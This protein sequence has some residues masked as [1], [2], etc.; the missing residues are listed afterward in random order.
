MSDATHA[1]FDRREGES[2]LQE[3]DDF[4]KTINRDDPARVERAD[5]PP[6]RADEAEDV[7][8]HSDTRVQQPGDEEPV[9]RPSRPAD[10]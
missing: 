6:T 3:R 1:E 9:S 5:R 8:D 10:E 2:H 4:E 7:G